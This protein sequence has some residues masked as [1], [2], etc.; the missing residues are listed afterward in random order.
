MDDERHKNPDEVA[1]HGHITS[2]AVLRPYRKLGLAAKLM[3]QANYAMR[4][5]YG[6]QQ[7][8]LHVRR[9]NRAALH[10]Y[11]HSMG[12][13][14][15]LVEKAY[16]ADGEDAFSMRKDLGRPIGKWVAVEEGRLERLEKF[17]EEESAEEKKARQRREKIEAPAKKEDEAKTAATGK[18]PEPAA[19]K[20][21]AN[22]LPDLPQQTKKKGAKGGKKKK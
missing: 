14:E 7:C 17:K 13:E 18:N 1:P 10:L 8:S 15:V 6:S 3:E 5:T 11:R 4:E 16:Y 9:S 20:P 21:K 19:E 2:L 22:F 12:F